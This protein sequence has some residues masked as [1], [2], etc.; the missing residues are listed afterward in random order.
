MHRDMT[1]Y[2]YCDIYMLL[3]EMS[4]DD[5]KR[6]FQRAKE[7]E[8][9][10]ICAYAILETIGLFDIENDFIYQKALAAVSEAPNFCLKVVSPKDKKV[11]IYQTVDVNDRFFMEERENALK[12]ADYD[13]KT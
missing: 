9:E 2:K 5:I 6:V 10:K 1:L 8:M 4:E 13:A 7:L 11:L 12:E 3:S